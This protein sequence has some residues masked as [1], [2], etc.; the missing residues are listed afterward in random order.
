M[1]P[2]I[3]WPASSGHPK[4]RESATYVHGPGHCELPDGRRRSSNELG[5]GVRSRGV[6]GSLADRI[7]ERGKRFCCVTTRGATSGFSMALGA[8]LARCRRSFSAWAC[9]ALTRS[10]PTTFSLAASRLPTSD[11][12][13]AF[14][15]LAVALVPAS[16]WYLRPHLLRKQVRG[17]GRRALAQGRRLSL[18]WRVPT[19]ASISQ[20]KARGECCRILL[21]RY[22]N[23]NKTLTCQSIVFSRTRQRDKRSH[24]RAGNKNPERRSSN[25]R[26][27][28]NKTER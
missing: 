2:G 21:G 25:D 20:G 18:P 17:R 3:R 26:L 24:R 8:V 27:L 11:F 12:P 13:Q 22:Q 16:R 14:R 10:S 1:R 4:C 23:S 28:E 7:R 5:C 15:V 19:G 9:W 6:R